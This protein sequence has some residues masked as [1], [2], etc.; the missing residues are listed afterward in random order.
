[1][2]NLQG[3]VA[4]I[5]GAASGIGRAVAT[6]A[7]AEGMKVVLADIEENA[8]KEATDDQLQIGNNLGKINGWVARSAVIGRLHEDVSGIAR[9]T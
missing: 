2:E 6:R 8:L 4:V 1:M 7:A 9:N 5:T 3:K